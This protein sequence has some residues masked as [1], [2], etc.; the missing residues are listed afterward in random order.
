[1]CFTGVSTVYKVCLLP[2]PWIGL[3]NPRAFFPRSEF[4]SII[5][6]IVNFP[7][8]IRL[9]GTSLVVLQWPPP[10]TRS[11]VSISGGG[12]PFNRI[13]AWPTGS[14]VSAGAITVMQHSLK[15]R[16]T[17]IHL[18]D[19]EAVMFQL[20]VFG[21]K[22]LWQGATCCHL[23]IKTNSPKQKAR[24]LSSRCFTS[25]CPGVPHLKPHKLTSD[26]KSMTWQLTINKVTKSHLCFRPF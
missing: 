1:M 5:F 4:K 24:D 6:L 8:S 18:I 7:E 2:L 19:K 22:F 20:G 14:V 17:D 26:C 13:F 10:F 11:W 3:S 23:N 16:G 12:L 15:D 9:C 25:L 21:C